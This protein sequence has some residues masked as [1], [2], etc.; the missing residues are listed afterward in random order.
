MH[1]CPYA[2]RVPCPQWL[3]W[4][5]DLGSIPEAEGNATDKL[6]SVESEG[7]LESC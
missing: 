4:V 3:M 1:A 7:H 6:M 2:I 5:V